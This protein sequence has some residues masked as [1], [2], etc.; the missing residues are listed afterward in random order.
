MMIFS[1][2]QSPSEN[3]IT[4]GNITPNPPRSGSINDNNYLS[5]ELYPIP[6]YTFISK[7][8]NVKH[9]GGVGL[10]NNYTFDFKLRSDLEFSPS[11]YESIFAELAQPHG[12]NIIV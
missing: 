7:H 4:S 1:S 3:I 11:K 10:Y 8:R 5:Y 6:N 2:G 12:K 9:G